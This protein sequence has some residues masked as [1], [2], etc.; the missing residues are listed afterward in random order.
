MI[1][2]LIYITILQIGILLI[3]TL[4]RFYF[5]FITAWLGQTVVK[6]LRVAVYKR[7]L[8]LNL[9]QYDKTPIGTLTTRT[10]NDIE[11][12]NDIFS[13]GLI[14]IISDLLS[15]ISILL[16]M[17]LSNWQLTLICLAPFPILIVATYFF[18]E[19]VNKSFIRVR[20][21]VAA[22][23]A[24]VQEHITG[25]QIVQAF[26]AEEREFNKFKKINQEHRN[27]N[28]KAIFAYSVFF[29]IVE[30]VLAFSTGLLVWWGASE[31]L[32]LVRKTGSFTD[33]RNHC[34]L[35]IPQSVI[36]AIATDC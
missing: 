3:E 6:D 8:G 27:A 33:R 1:Q 7:V 10:I 28:I 19:T 22:L 25:M 18:K 11:A 36:P 34:F 5:S 21:A 32:A 9:S 4:L 15:I 26:A 14:P 30:I 35:F 13:E 31:V 12:I 2:L 17:F 24:F 16:F 20:N 23:N 29:P